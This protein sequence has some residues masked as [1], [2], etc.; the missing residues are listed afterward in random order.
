M[1]VKYKHIK[2]NGFKY[3]IAS[4]QVLVPFPFS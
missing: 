3:I 1:F 2:S 4:K